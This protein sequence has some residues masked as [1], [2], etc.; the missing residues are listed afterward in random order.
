MIAPCWTAS[1]WQTAGQ[2]IAFELHAK[3]IFMV[4]ICPILRAKVFSSCFCSFQPTGPFIPPKFDRKL[5]TFVLLFANFGHLPALTIPLAVPFLSM[6]TL[7]AWHI[8]DKFAQ[9][10]MEIAVSIK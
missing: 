10:V 6:K 3:A 8:W 7:A 4:F 2:I 1:W 5:C 9:E